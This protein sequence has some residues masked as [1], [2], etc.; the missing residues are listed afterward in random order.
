M[1]YPQ[2]VYGLDH[3]HMDIGRY[4]HQCVH[5]TRLD[6]R[7]SIVSAVE[8]GKTSDM[9]TDAVQVPNTGS[10]SSPTMLTQLQSLMARSS[11]DLANRHPDYLILAGRLEA[12]NLHRT[13]RKSFVNNVLKI[14]ECRPAGVLEP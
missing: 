3:A 14:H 1:L 7:C 5:R 13:V 4:V 8:A 11:A 6:L 2:H 10:P 12:I 9:T